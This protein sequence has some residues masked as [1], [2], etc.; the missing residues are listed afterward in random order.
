MSAGNGPPQGRRAHERRKTGK[1]RMVRLAARCRLPARLFGPAGHIFAGHHGVFTAGAAAAA[2][3][4]RRA[5]LRLCDD[6]V[7]RF[8]YGGAPHRRVHAAPARRGVDFCLRPVAGHAARGR[9]GRGFRRGQR[10]C[11]RGGFRFRNCAAH[12]DDRFR[13]ARRLHAVLRHAGGAG[14]AA[15]R[16]VHRLFFGRGAVH[17]RFAAVLRGHDDPNGRAAGA[18]CGAVHAAV[19]DAA[20]AAAERSARIAPARRGA[21]VFISA[22]ARCPVRRG[23]AALAA[24]NLR[25]RRMAGRA[26]R[27]AYQSAQQ[28]VGGRC[29]GALPD[30]DGA[31]DHGQ[32][33]GYRRER[34]HARPAPDDRHARARGEGLR[35]GRSL[36]SRRG[37]GRV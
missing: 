8:G 5:A 32:P 14:A 22:G 20:A 7:R 13:T 25:A 37:A 27:A 2:V 17:G 29:G 23:A 33:A 30:G 10:H 3:H 19:L 36:S 28:P 1:A 6:D 9:A 31:A 16:L 24:R 35:F 18:V 34:A 15:V 26:A 4:H 21:D 11:A 12:G